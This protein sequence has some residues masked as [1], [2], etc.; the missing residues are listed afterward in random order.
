MARCRQLGVHRYLLKPVRQTELRDSILAILS[1]G[2]NPIVVLDPA[3]TAAGAAPARRLRILVADDNP[4]NQRVLQRLLEKLHY[5]VTL[6]ANGQEAVD[7]MA[8]EEFDL[9]L[10]DVQMPVMDGIAATAAIR[11]RE[12]TSNAHV[13]ILAVTAHAMQG[14]RERFLTAGMDGY[15]SKPIGRAELIEAIATALP[16]R[17]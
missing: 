7:R 14:D 6:V 8:A 10:M 16:V 4:V 11:D 9:V 1:G 15:I 5:I 12:R 17:T 13:P 3:V 2:D